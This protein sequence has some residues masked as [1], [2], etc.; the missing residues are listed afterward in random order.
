MKIL[1]Q[2]KGKKEST[3]AATVA[4]VKDNSKKKKGTST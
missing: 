1:P 2:N 4:A 3:K